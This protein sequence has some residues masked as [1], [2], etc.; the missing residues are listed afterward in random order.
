MNYIDLS[1]PAEVFRT[2]LPSA[3]IPAATVTLFN[4]SD[5]VIASVEVLLRLLDKEGG[6]TE[7]LA[8]R[9]R[10]LNGRPHSTFLL[11]VPC[12][13]SAGLKSLDVT[14]EK[15]WYA[16]NETWRRDP[17]NAVEYTPNTLPVSPALTNLKYAAGETAVGYPSMQNGLWVCVCGRPN[18]E[19]ETWC[20]RCG[21]QMEEIFSRFTPEAVETQISLKERQLDLN[22]RNM[23]EDTIR[24]Q[25][26]REEEYKQKKA[27]RGNRI[28]ILF[29]AAFAVALTAASLFFFEPLLRLSAGKRALET[30]DAAGAKKVFKALGRFGGANELIPEC[31]WLIAQEAADSATDAE[32]MARASALL[33]AVKDRPEAIDR[34]NQVDLFRS[35]LLLGNNRWEDALKALESLPEDYP[36]RA[37]LKQS[38]L[39]AKAWA[40]QKTGKYAEAREVWLALGD[41]PGAKEQAALCIYEPAKQL[42]EQGDWDGAIAM[43]SSIPDY[44]D[45]RVKTLECHYHKAEALEAAGDA[46]GASREYLLAGSWGDAQER[47]NGRIYAQA[48]EL[49]AAGDI[50]GAQALYSAI[51]DYRDANDRDRVCRY[52]LAQDAAS[53]M[54]YTTVLEF[55]KGVPDDYRDT[56]ALR[57]EASYKKAQVATRNEDWT[58]VYE[59][60]AD[61]D[62]DSLK[63]KYRDIENMYVIACEK[64]GKEPYQ[65][66]EAAPE[67]G[68]T[69]PAGETTPAGNTVPDGTE[70]TPSP[71]PAEAPATPEP[72]PF[73]VTEDD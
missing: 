4:L 55:L 69:A 46:D 44:Q 58:A 38:C 28:R 60:L 13:F 64:I 62:R 43:F 32:E 37:E 7:R 45:S 33:R 11:T 56:K 9:G 16:D 47:Y 53:I 65:D 15:V 29:A 19:G 59:L 21:R 6:E 31:D 73:L 52:R 12:A 34:A 57:G 35:R 22:S 54:E 18:P 10:A 39:T 68:E 2:A 3:E 26:I 5:R 63:R 42:M 51:P 8:F 23:R 1:C 72:N 25:R 61:L 71:A 27:R 67:P 50:K 24:M 36:G 49:E 30:G 17:A 14:V 41:M 20:A 70:G 40:L 66:T 48:E